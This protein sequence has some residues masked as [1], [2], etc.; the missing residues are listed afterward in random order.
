MSGFDRSSLS[1]YKL[2]NHI[3]LHHQQIILVVYHVQLGL[4]I[5][6]RLNVD[7]VLL[8]K[9]LRDKRRRVEALTCRWHHE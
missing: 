7:V 3:L 2:H 9:H 5:K 4:I 6:L 1:F 8:S